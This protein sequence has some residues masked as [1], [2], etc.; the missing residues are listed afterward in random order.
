MYQ[1]DMILVRLQQGSEG[2]Q[3]YQKSLH[4]N[5]GR[6]VIENQF[7]PKFKKVQNLLGGG[8]QENYGLFPQF[9]TLFF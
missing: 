6:A 8:G 3:R 4:F 1:F 5:F 2:M 9:G 7:F